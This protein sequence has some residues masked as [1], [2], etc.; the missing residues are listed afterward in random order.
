MLEFHF[1]YPLPFQIQQHANLSTPVE[2]FQSLSQ[3]VQRH[4]WRQVFFLYLF[5]RWKSRYATV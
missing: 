2:F 3:S 1:P 4:E 5:R